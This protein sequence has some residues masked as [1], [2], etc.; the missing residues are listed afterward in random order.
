LPNFDEV[1]EIF[2]LP[3]MLG[4]PDELKGFRQLERRK[5]QIT[6]RATV[7]IAPQ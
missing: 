3:A 7:F 4:V 2:Q 6:M 5:T 1:A